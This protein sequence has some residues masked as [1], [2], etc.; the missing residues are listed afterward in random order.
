MPGGYSISLIKG[1]DNTM[2]I[3]AI[4]VCVILVCFGLSRIL[5]GRSQ[6]QAAPKAA[7]KDAYQ[8]LRNSALQSSRAK[9]GLPPTSTP[10]QPWGVIMDWGLIEGTATVVAF[11]DGNASVYLSSGG[12]FIGGAS[13]EAIRKAAQKMVAVAAEVQPQTHATTTFPLPQDAQVIFYLLTDEGVF[14]TN[15]PQQELSSHRHPL[16]KLGDAGQDIITQYRLIQ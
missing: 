10:A 5:H 6:K 13:H 15:A 3:I 7:S 9:L 1:L 16:S 4:A 2:K 11:S 12:G 14:T 8:G